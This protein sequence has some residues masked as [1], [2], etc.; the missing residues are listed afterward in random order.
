MGDSLNVKG[1]FKLY[2]YM[3]APKYSIYSCSVIFFF[4]IYDENLPV[5]LAVCT[6]SKPVASVAF[7][8]RPVEF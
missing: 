7:I 6:Q 5:K 4:V 2:K 1:V 3:Y 8:A